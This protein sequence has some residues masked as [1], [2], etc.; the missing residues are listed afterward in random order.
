MTI[1]LEEVSSN[2]KTRIFPTVS[3]NFFANAWPRGAY[4]RETS[5]TRTLFRNPCLEKYKGVSWGKQLSATGLLLDQKSQLITSPSHEKVAFFGSIRTRAQ[6]DIYA[7]I[8]LTHSIISWT[9]QIVFA[10]SNCIFLRNPFLYD[11]SLTIMCLKKPMW[12]T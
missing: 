8:L 4:Q 7:V 9:K 5:R 11:L 6:R 10:R 3:D 2:V 12:I 1:S